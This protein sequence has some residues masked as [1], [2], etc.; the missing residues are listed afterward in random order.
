MGYSLQVPPEVWGA[1]PKLSALNLSKNQLQ[2]VNP[3]A[4]S[5]CIGLRQLLLQHNK[6]CDW[7]LPLNASALMNLTELNLSYNPNIP[8]LP[9]AA[10]SSCA[11]RLCT[12]DL[13]GDD[14]SLS[15]VDLAAGN[16]RTENVK[17]IVILGMILY[18]AICKTMRVSAPPTGKLTRSSKLYYSCLCFD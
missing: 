2:W 14:F 1:A 3:T 10:F 8:T 6:L 11:D 15:A 4:L 7:P 5:G 9:A 12:L 13:S 18:S 17:Q 16:M